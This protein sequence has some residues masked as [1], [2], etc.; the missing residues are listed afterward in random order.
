MDFVM[1]FVAV[2]PYSEE[3]AGA[4]QARVRDLLQQVRV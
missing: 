2:E 1:D 4:R 3:E